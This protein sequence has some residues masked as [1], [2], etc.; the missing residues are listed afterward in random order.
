MSF[1]QVTVFSTFL[2][3]VNERYV[4]AKLDMLASYKTY[5]EKYYF[6]PSLLRSTMVRYGALAERPYAEGF[7]ILRGVRAY[8]TG[9]IV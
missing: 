2:D 4:Q 6:D 9:G 1:D 3:G 7:D 8:H 5:S